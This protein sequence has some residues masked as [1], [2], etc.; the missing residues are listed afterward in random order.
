MNGSAQL[1][2]TFEAEPITLERTIVL[3]PGVHA[4]CNVRSARSA[5]IAIVLSPVHAAASTNGA[6]RGSARVLRH[7]P[8][9]PLVAGAESAQLHLPAEMLGSE[10]GRLPFV[11]DTARP[12]A[13]A[14]ALLAVLTAVTVAPPQ[15]GSP[16]AL[17]LEQSILQLTRGLVAI[18][19]DARRGADA[20]PPRFAAL[21]DSTAR[22]AVAGRVTVD[23]VAAELGCTP[24]EVR[25]ALAAGNTTFSAL[26][27]ECRLTALAERIRTGDTR[28]ALTQLP[29]QVG[30]ESYPQAARAF[31]ARFGMTMGEYRRFVRL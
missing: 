25:F 24:A 13:L 12:S 22:L 2:E 11:P 6:I 29:A 7:S 17:A 9:E 30:I 5:C 31:K 26:V 3:P 27:R 18:A 4:A 23:A 1:R 8:T 16:S 20:A 10:S 19:A 14:S 28:T 21:R 15:H